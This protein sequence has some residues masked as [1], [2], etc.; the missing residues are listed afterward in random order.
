MTS[1]TLPILAVAAGALAGGGLFLLVVAIR[2]LPPR[3]RSAGTD[4]FSRA[5]RDAFSIRGSIALIV[6]ILVLLITR[7]VVAAIGMALLAYSWQSL[8]GAASERRSISR[9]EGLATWTESLRDT[10][11]G[12]VGLEQAIPASIRVADSTIREPLVRLVDRLHTRMP[13][14]LALR[15]FAE[16]LDDASAD[17]I[18]AALIINSRL[19]GPGLRDLLGALADSVREELDMRRKVNSSRRSTRRSVQIVIAVSVLMALFL[20]VLDRS[21]LQPYDSVFGQLVL[22]VIVAIYGLGIWWLRKLA[23]FDTPQRLLGTVA[24][25]TPAA[26]AAEPETVAAWRGGAA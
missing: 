23:K 12:A 2:G 10:I 14:H 15:R 16:D 24:A 17:M 20:A 11:A 26:P 22:A 1:S 21:F 13:M 8:S 25:V 6:G 19:R 4:R 18:I 3:V 9:L 5:I 7:W